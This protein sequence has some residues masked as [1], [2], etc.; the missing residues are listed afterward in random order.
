MLN[1]LEEGDILL[2]MDSGVYFIESS[3]PLIDYF[4]SSDLPLMCFT[5]EN[6]GLNEKKYTK[7]DC[8][9]ALGCDEEKYWK[10]PQRV[11]TY[12]LW[13]KCKTSLSLVD[14]WL[15][16]CQSLQLINNSPSKH[17]EYSEFQYHRHDQSIF[18]LLT[19]KYDI[20]ATIVEGTDINK[21]RL[22]NTKTIHHP[23]Y[24]DSNKQ[25]RNEFF[26]EPD[27]ALSD[28]I[29]YLFSNQK[30][31]STTLGTDL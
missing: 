13:R 26:K 11:A 9:I 14:E 1:E 16:Y 23:I 25:N 3:Q 17:P 24:W 21:I 7:R 27:F 12:N 10:S 5:R 22:N 18:S 6:S 4:I 8:L 15:H 19:K 31:Y 20:P 30:T 28:K 2:Y 29:S